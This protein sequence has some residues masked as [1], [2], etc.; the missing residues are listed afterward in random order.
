MGAQCVASGHCGAGARTFENPGAPK[1]P[2]PCAQVLTL[3]NPDE[4]WARDALLRVNAVLGPATRS[5][6]VYE[7]IEMV[8]HPLGVHLNEAV[9]AAFWVRSLP[10]RHTVCKRIE[11]VVH[12]LGVHLNEAV[13]AAFWVRPFL[14]TGPCLAGFRALHSWEY[15]E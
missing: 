2:Y 9:A 15:E 10:H 1:K 4:S 13:A 5:H 8:V 6:T 11:M 12:P 7:H 3:W 14:R